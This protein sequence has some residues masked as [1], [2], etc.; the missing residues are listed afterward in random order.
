MT[1]RG[2]LIIVEGLDRSGKST[3][4][5]RLVEGLVSG[6]HK[7]KLM[8]FPDRTTNIGKLINS[9]LTDKDNNLEDHAVH[10]LFS[11]NRWEQRDQMMKEL[12]DG[13]TLIVDRYA[14]SGVAYSSSK[15]QLSLEWC[16]QPDRG[17]PRPDAVLFFEV[18]EHVAK[19]RAE[20]GNEKYETT[21]IQ[22][23]VRENFTKLRESYWQTVNADLS[24]DEVYCS[25]EKMVKTAMAKVAKLPIEQ[26][27]M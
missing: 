3:Q 1:H 20:F 8:R 17:L 21:E 11:A 7:A 6:G 27:W 25:V 10:L 26:L 15:E 5:K 4:C 16:K 14:Y 12:N 19:Q 18:S 2:A 22:R 23:R 24:E 13:V 9:Y